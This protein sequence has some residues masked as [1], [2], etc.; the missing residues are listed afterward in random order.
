MAGT[1][2]IG[3]LITG[4][5][6]ATIID[7]LI[8][9]SRRRID[10]VVSDQTTYSDK[11]SS[12]QSLNTKLSSFKSK[13]D[14]LRSIDTF[15][16]FKTVTTTNSSNFKAN[17]LLSLS[18]TT[19]ANPGTHTV[20]F[21]S[22]SQLAQA[23]QL[24][25]QSY[26]SATTALSISGEF[27]INGKAISITTSDSLDG[28]AT[29]I[30]NANSGTNATGVTASILSIS[31]SDNRLIL[32]SDN[33]GNDKFSILDAS[34]SG[35]D[36]LQTLGFTANT[37]TVKNT[38]SDGAKS[39]ELSSSE[40]AVGSLLGLTSAQN[41]TVAI[42]GSSVSIDLSTDSLTAIASAIN[43]IT[44]VTATVE[45]TT[46]DGVTTY[47]I[48]ISGTTSFTDNNNVLETLGILEGQQGSVAEVHTASTAHTEIGGDPVT[49]TSRFRDIDTGGASNNVTNGDTITIS[50][51]DH[52]G[53]S[54]S[55][56]YIIDNNRNIINELLTEIETVL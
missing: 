38:T 56:T 6:T 27:V 42:A 41:G 33:T 26:S 51:T 52:N 20:K 19:D 53:N 4:L 44:G 12:Y 14:I 1:S 8:A 16:V 45:S 25:S 54:V 43:N 34:A 24:S 39:D 9:V 30:N 50:G 10:L 18:T 55:G 49:S 11:L 40:T 46:T 32:T 3:G 37:T 23:R 2:T 21:T 17:D 22:S 15:N 36:I 13:A 31:S 35:T 29:K 7:Q 48:D 5:D 47:Y 28:I